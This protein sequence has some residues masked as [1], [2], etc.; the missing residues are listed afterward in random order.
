VKVAD[1]LRAKGNRVLTIAPEATLHQAAHTLAASRVGALVVSTDGRRVQG[2]VSERDVVQAMA[3]HGARGMELTVS[4]AMTT[5]VVTCTPEDRITAMMAV[6]TAKRCRHIPVVV[7]GGLSGIV[8]IG[9]LVKARLEDLEL[10]SQVLR[11]A[12]LATH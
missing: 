6:M 5:P 9:D 12:Y 7:D 4:E 2:M 8:S 11:D 3:S 1:I 10:E